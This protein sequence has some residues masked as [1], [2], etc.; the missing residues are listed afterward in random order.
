MTRYEVLDR[1]YNMAQHNMQAYGTNWGQEPK[2]GF[3][4]EWM[5]AKEA[6]D[7]LKAML[8]EVRC[9][10]WDPETGEATNG[11]LYRGTLS[12]WECCPRADGKGHYVDRVEIETAHRADHRNYGGQRFTFQCTRE[13]QE[14]WIDNGRYDEERHRRYDEDKPTVLHIWVNDIGYIFH[15]AWA[16]E[17]KR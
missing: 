11:H 10:Y 1:A 7:I 15:L 14:Q 5:E 13:V 16:D 8:D 12:G 3:D 17:E 9:M 4:K 2:E 6:A